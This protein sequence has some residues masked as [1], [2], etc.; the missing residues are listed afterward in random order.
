MERSNIKLIVGLGNPTREYAETRHNVGFMALEYFYKKR[1]L[2]GEPHTFKSSTILNTS[3]AGQKIILA[4]PLTYMNLS[5]HAV[6]ELMSFYKADIK[7]FLLVHDDMDLPPGKIKAS[8][9]GGVGHN[10]VSSVK[11]FVSGEF[12]RFRIGIGRPGRGE[13]GIDYSDFVLTR[14]SE[15]EEKEILKAL[16]LCSDMLDAFI[17]GGLDAAQRLGNK[18]PKP[19]KEKKEGEGAKEGEGD[20]AKLGEGAKDGAKDGTGAI[21]GPGTSPE[22]RESPK[23]G[24]QS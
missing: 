2:K 7:D 16:E 21:D 8:A 24:P 6:R 14:F 1:G 5:G 22:P 3:Y 17:R 13:E 23:E 18:S 4:W 15:D 9:K 12:G 11:D 20:G 10:G 19:K